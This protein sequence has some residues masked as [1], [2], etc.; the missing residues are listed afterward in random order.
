M[1]NDHGASRDDDSTTCFII[2]TITISTIFRRP[3]SIPVLDATATN[4]L[5]HTRNGAGNPASGW[6]SR[7]R[8]V[9]GSARTSIIVRE[10]WCSRPAYR[11]VGCWSR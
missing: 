1:P 9:P 8:L 5:G 3:T 2:D 6:E 4:G 11:I 7:R 10:I